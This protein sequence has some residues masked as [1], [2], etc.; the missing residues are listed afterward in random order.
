[1]KPSLTRTRV[2]STRAAV[3]GN[4]VRLVA[5]Y[6]ELYPVGHAGLA[7]QPRRPDRFLGGIARGRIG[8]QED[9]R[10]VDVVEQRLALARDVH[11]A[12]RHGHHVRARRLV[13]GAHDRMRGILAGAHD[14]PRSELAAGDDKRIG[15]GGIVPRCPG[16]KISSERPT[17]G[18][19]PREGLRWEGQPPDRKCSFPTPT[20]RPPRSSRS[21]PR[22]RR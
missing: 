17:R 19:E 18:K 7:P 9:G 11:P 10:G 3:S 6:L 13:R 2:A 16:A 22:H 1:M 8:Q 21:R 12:H 20:T 15:H 5:D 4:R 14:Q